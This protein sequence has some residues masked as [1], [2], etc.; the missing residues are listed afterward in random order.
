[1]H[2]Q[3]RIR[4]RRDF[5]VLTSFTWAHSIDNASRS[6]DLF[7]W[8]PDWPGNIDRG[9][10]GFDVR[11]SLAT[12]F[13]ASPRRWRGWSL[14]GVFRART[15]FP[16]TVTALD[17]QLAFGIETRTNL[18][19]GQPVWIGDSNA[20]G[21]R[22]LNPRAFRAP[23]LPQPGTLGRNA[24]QGFGMHQLDVALQ[25]RS[26]RGRTRERAPAAGSL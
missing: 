17:P 16:L 9:D 25:A 6:V 26:R 18:V 15:G 20:P 7:V 22:R 13:T 5:D 24:I 4:P 21:G 8:Q 1:M 23:S 3:V 11:H 2:A 19:A 14:H 12:A 10:S